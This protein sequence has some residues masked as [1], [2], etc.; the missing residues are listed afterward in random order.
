MSFWPANQEHEEQ[1][2]W[3]RKMEQEKVFIPRRRR[4]ETGGFP[5]GKRLVA[6]KSSGTCLTHF[7]INNQ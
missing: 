3:K 1:E 7:S 2:K 5:I 6:G 4:D